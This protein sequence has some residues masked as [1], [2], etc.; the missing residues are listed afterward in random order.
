M[1]KAFAA[2]LLNL[3]QSLT[4]GYSLQSAQLLIPAA[5][6]HLRTLHHFAFSLRVHPG[7]LPFLKL[8]QDPQYNPQ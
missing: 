3:G 1:P 6:L 4:L 7:Q 2:K 8:E 5:I